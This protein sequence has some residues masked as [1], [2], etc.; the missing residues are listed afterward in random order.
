MRNLTGQQFGRLVAQWP[1]GIVPD[2]RT[3]WL[4]LC[5]CG[6]TALVRDNNLITGNTKTCG[7]SYKNPTDPRKAPTLRIIHGHARYKNWSLTYKSWACM[8]QRCTNPNEIGYHRYGGRGITVY[9]PWANFVNF[10]A[11]MGERPV[12]T[13]I[14]RINPDGNYEPG[15]CRWATPKEQRLNQRVY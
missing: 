13:T 11:D 8:L 12:G 5:E 6:Q 9:E 15:N 3:L 10:L 7:C 4:C 2:R 14:D 1:A